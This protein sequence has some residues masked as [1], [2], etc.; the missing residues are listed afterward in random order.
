MKALDRYVRLRSR[1]EAAALPWLWLGRRGRLT[2]SGIA[3]ALRDRGAAAGVSMLHAH[4]FRHSY[5]HT[6]LAGGMQETDLMQLAGWRSREMVARYAAS[7]RSD[8]A[9]AAARRFNPGDEL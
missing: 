5:A 3:Q 7:T 6:M 1:H 8:R 2:D 9:I 4:Q